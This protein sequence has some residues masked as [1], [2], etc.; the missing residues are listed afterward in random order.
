II[1]ACHQPEPAGGSFDAPGAGRCL[2]TKIDSG[3]GGVGYSSRAL[4]VRRSAN[5]PPGVQR[6]PRGQPAPTCDG[7]ERKGGYISSQAFST[8][9]GTNNSACARAELP[10]L[11]NGLA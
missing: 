10:Q 5:H 2:F 7:I 1:T 6:F 3:P 11:L 4:P 9:D 8:N